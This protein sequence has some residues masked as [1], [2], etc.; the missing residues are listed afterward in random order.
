MSQ[1][2]N[3]LLLPGITRDAVTEATQQRDKEI[4]FSTVGK[5]EKGGTIAKQ[6][7]GAVIASGTVLG[8]ITASG[9]YAPYSNVAADG[10]EVA[11]AVLHAHVDTRIG[12]VLGNI[13]LGGELKLDQL[14][15]LDAAAIVDLN[16][17]TDAILNMFKF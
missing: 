8:R 3:E 17:R 4:L 5:V 6:G 9:K 16:G 10:T 12:D 7:A 14:V 2:Q 13:I 1:N 15:G 11:V